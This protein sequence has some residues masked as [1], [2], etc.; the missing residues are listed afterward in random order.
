MLAER[1]LCQSVNTTEVIYGDTSIELA[2]ELQKYA[3]VCYQAQGRA[4][5]L[6]AVER[7]INI[8]KINY[9]HDCTQIKELNE[10]KQYLATQ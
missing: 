1:L 7:A 10:F 2:N 5:A 3:E 9:G 8:F 6:K 4:D